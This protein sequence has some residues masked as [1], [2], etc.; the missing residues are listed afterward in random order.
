MLLPSNLFQ[1]LILLALLVVITSFTVF[2]VLLALAKPVNAAL[3]VPPAP[4]LKPVSLTITP[5]K[6]SNPVGLVNAGGT[7]T[8]TIAFKSDTAGTVI[9]TDTVP[10]TTSYKAGTISSLVATTTNVVTADDSN[11]STM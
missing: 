3:P 6:I 10:A 1:R 7:V 2:S 8:F 11:S 4:F 5:T 9:V